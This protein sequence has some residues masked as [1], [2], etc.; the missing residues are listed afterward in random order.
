M[1]YTALPIGWALPG[2][3]NP[4]PSPILL[5][6]YDGG[7]S[8]LIVTIFSP[9]SKTKPSALFYSLSLSSGFLGLIFLY[10]SVSAKT[11]FICLSKAMNVPTRVRESWIVT[12]TL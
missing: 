9:L 6:Y 2:P 11:K 1:I 5:A 12:L 8:A 4:A 10:S 3:A 7:A